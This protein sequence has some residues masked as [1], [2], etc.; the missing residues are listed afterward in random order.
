MK[1]TFVMKTSWPQNNHFCLSLVEKHLIKYSNSS[2][3]K[4]K[5]CLRVCL[6]T[7]DIATKSSVSMLSRPNCLIAKWRE[8]TEMQAMCFG[9]T[10][11]FV[12]KRSTWLI[13]VKSTSYDKSYQTLRHLNTCAAPSRVPIVISPSYIEKIKQNF[14]IR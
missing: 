5:R 2:K 1:S 14:W 12:K 7:W 4:T 8:P 11:I 13:A 3:W 10:F 9:R 6:L